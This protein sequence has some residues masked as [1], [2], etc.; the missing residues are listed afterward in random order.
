IEGKLSQ[1]SKEVNARIDP[2]L[3]E[4][5]RSLR[6]PDGPPCSQRSKFLLMDALKLSIED[7]SHEG[8]GIPLYDAIKCMKTFFGWKEPQIVKPHEKGI[9]P[10]YLLTWKQVLA[11]LQDIENEDKIPKTKT[12]KKTSQLKWVLG[13]N[14]APEK[15]DFEDCKDIGDLKQYNSDEPKLR[16]LASWIQS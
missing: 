11:E 8:E 9:N 1:M 6:L 16:S 5:P 2:F 13:E 12:M 10:N 14:M 7:P 4:T 15:V 3:K